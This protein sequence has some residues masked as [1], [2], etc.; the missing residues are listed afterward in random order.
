[1]TRR[2]GSLDPSRV[3]WPTILASTALLGIAGAVL[4]F[5]GALS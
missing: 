1:M 4:A 3:L 2:P 5:V